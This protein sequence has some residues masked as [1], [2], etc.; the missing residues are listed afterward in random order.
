MEKLRVSA[1]K[2][3]LTLHSPQGNE[4]LGILSGISD[5]RFAESLLQQLA[6]MHLV[7]PYLPHEIET[8]FPVHPAFDDLIGKM[9][10]SEGQE[11][12][13]ISS[14]S[15][16]MEFTAPQIVGGKIAV[17]YSGGKDSMWNM[18]WAQEEVG[19]EN[20]LAVHFGGLNRTSAKQERKYTLLQH[21]RIGFPLQTVELLNSSKSSGWNV[22]R[23]RDIFLTGLA[24][25]ASLEFGADRIVLEGSFARG[26]EES[27]YPF[28]GRESTW[29]YFNTLLRQLNIPVQIVW[30]DRGQ[31]ATIRDLLENRLEWLQY[32]CNCFSPSHYAVDIRRR[33][34]E[35]MP[36]LSLYESQCGMCI[37]CRPVI[38]ARILYDPFVMQTAHEGDIHYFLTSTAQWVKKKWKTHEDLL[39]GDFIETLRQ[40]LFQ[41]NLHHEFEWLWKPEYT[42]S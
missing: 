34:I 36:T 25:P 26:E 30:K 17:T 21:E 3:V 23:S 42:I 37:K 29:Y 33:F 5:T 1:E 7:S 2:N 9:Y 40:S 24:I 41:R 20:V 11:R 31:I 39:A 38:L 18:W 10:D 6:L 14:P 22:L 16:L 27:Q 15:N 32:V 12:P 8:N 19:V 28:N 13:E 35:K 4:R